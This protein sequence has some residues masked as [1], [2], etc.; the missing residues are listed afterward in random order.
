MT[1]LLLAAAGGHADVVRCLLAA[2][3]DAGADFD[4][5]HVEGNTPLLFAVSGTVR[6]W[7]ISCWR[8]IPGSTPFA[9][10]DLP[11]TAAATGRDARALTRE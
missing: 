2:G 4:A 8:P 1:P 6:S 5:A 7:R 10:Q 3:A 9:P 11:A